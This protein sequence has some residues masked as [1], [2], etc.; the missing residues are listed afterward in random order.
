MNMGCGR[1]VPYSKDE[2]GPFNVHR[3]V[4]IRM[5]AQGL[6]GGLYIPKAQFRI[7]PTWVD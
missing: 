5:E 2:D 7:E 6:D 1:V 4:K 3:T